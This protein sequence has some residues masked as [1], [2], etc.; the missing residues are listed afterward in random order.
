[1]DGEGEGGR[2]ILAACNKRRRAVHKRVRGRGHRLERCE[3]PARRDPH[4][5]ERV[6][7]CAV[8][9]D[10]RAFRLDGETM[11]SLQPVEVVERAS[12][13]RRGL[14]GFRR[15]PARR[16][17]PCGARRGGGAESPLQSGYPGHSTPSGG[18]AGVATASCCE[19]SSATASTD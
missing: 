2:E 14:G 7:L 10:R 9:F 12:P 16:G 8:Q 18:A 1:G 13:Y 5:G 17:V 3:R 19:A 6:V 11:S 4:L 15:G